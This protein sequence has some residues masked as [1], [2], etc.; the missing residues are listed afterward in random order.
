MVVKE[1]IQLDNGNMVIELTDN[2]TIQ[3]ERIITSKPYDYTGVTKYETV[4]YIARI[5]NVE[6]F[7][8]VSTSFTTSEISQARVVSLAEFWHELRQFTM[9]PYRQWGKSE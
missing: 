2:R 6:I 1:V 7:N 3:V 5:D 8:V 9:Y 4:R